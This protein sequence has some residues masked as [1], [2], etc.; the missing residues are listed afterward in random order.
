MGKVTNILLSS[1]P[2]YLK[3]LEFLNRRTNQKWVYVDN[4]DDLKYLTL[5][6]KKIN[7]IYVPHWSYKI[8]ESIYNKYEVILFHM[9]DLPFGRGG[10][11]LQNLIK[12]GYEKTKVSAIRVTDGIDEG[13]IYLKR[14][15]SLN[16][17]AKQIFNRTSSIITNMILKINENIT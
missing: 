5:N 15:L 14:S 10:S 16:G 6:E 13:P 11:P 3:T 4:K 8:P 12:L 17:S 2:V 1:N 9:T 7:K